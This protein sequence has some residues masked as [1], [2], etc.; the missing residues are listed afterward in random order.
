MLNLWSGRRLS[1]LGRIAIV[2]TLALS[3]LVYNCSVLDTP[4]DF[5]KEVNKVIFPFIWNFKPDKIK[6]NTLT[7]P[8]FKGGLSMVNFT[9][10]TRGFSR[11]RWEFSVLAEGRHIFFH[12]KD[13]TETGNRARKVS[14]T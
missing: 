5:A 14:G 10:G 11:V 12:Y 1:I 7:G 9:L 4:T 6:R 2:K 13:L 8:V 3:K